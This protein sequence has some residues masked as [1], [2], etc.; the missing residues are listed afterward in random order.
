[1]T[2]SLFKKCRHHFWHGGEHVRVLY[3]AGVVVCLAV[4]QFAVFRAL[5]FFK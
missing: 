4:L 5:G 1:M 3:R 2:G